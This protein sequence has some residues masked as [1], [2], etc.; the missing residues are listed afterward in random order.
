MICFIF[1][2]KR[3]TVRQTNQIT[4]KSN[5]IENQ[6]GTRTA[7]NTEAGL[8]QGK[9]TGLETNTR[10]AIIPE[11]S[12]HQTTWNQFKPHQQALTITTTALTDYRFEFTADRD[13]KPCINFWASSARNSNQSL[14]RKHTPPCKLNDMFYNTHSNQIVKW[15]VT[16]TVK[17]KVAGSHPLQTR[18]ILSV[19][20]CI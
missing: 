3:L 10:Q 2:Y 8:H 13:C 20:I 6:H 15:L 16:L 11:A 9:A 14:H 18:L 7:I 1:A 12:L 19:C 5:W 4:R 17:L